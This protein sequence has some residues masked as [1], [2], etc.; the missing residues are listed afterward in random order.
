MK[1]ILDYLKT[2]LYVIFLVFFGSTRRINKFIDEQAKYPDLM[3]AI[4]KAYRAWIIPAVLAWGP[5]I[6]VLGAIF[7]AYGAINIPGATMEMVNYQRVLTILNTW[8][9]TGQS[10]DAF[11]TFA[12]FP[13]V[14]VF[15]VEWIFFNFLRNRKNLLRRIEHREGLE[16]YR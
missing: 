5:G 1:K 6:F 14:I 12:A 16:I 13:L 15:G 4:V 2:Q 11:L 3:Y 10:L 9:F 7:E 8:E